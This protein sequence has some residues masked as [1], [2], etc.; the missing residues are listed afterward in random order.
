MSGLRILFYGRAAHEPLRVVAEG[1]SAERLHPTSTW[2]L[3]RRGGRMDRR[4]YLQVPSLDE[5]LPW[6]RRPFSLLLRCP[7]KHTQSALRFHCPLHARRAAGISL[8]KGIALPLSAATSDRL[9]FTPLARPQSTENS[10]PAGLQPARACGGGCTRARPLRIY[11]PVF[12]WGSHP[13]RLASI[14]ELDSSRRTGVVCRPT[15]P[16]RQ[17]SHQRPFR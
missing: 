9:C 5:Q 12:A 6:D 8:R 7:R 13:I 17:S 2:K 4:K 1:Y 3:S 11:E 16:R 14:G 15:S 10:A